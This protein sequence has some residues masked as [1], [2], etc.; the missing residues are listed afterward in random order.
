MTHP[1][2]VCIFALEI[3]LLVASFVSVFCWPMLTDGVTPA[4]IGVS[5]GS[6]LNWCIWGFYHIPHVPRD[7]FL[8]H[9]LYQS[10]SLLLWC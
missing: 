7:G 6:I 8:E 3:E 5:R 2:F 10:L 4:A 1:T 9:L